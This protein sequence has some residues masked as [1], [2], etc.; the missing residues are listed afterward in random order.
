ML[1]PWWNLSSLP[2]LGFAPFAFGRTSSLT[3]KDLSLLSPLNSSLHPPSLSH[4]H[5]RAHAFTDVKHI[6]PV[7]SHRTQTQARTLSTSK[8]VRRPV[9]LSL[10]PSLSRSPSVPRQ[11]D[12]VSAH[13]VFIFARQLFC[14]REKEKEKTGS[15]LRTHSL[16]YPSAFPQVPAPSRREVK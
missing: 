7:S 13:I 9:T 5:H 3:R 4:T 12:S 15:C 11:I 8:T 14:Q 6:F 1:L 10:L 16:G 2:L